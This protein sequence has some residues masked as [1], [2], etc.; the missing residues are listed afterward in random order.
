MKDDREYNHKLHAMIKQRGISQYMLASN[1]REK[2][3]AIH[4]T[5]LSNII[6]GDRIPPPLWKKA[7]AAELKCSV[8]EIF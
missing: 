8:S 2:G 1:L 4:E 5:A 7:I 6:N 3:W